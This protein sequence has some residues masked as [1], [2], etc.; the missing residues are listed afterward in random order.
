MNMNKDVLKKVAN[1]LNKLNCTWAIGG[2]VMLNHFG[3]VESPNDIDILI[4]ASQAKQIKEFMDSIGAY[5]KLPSK[6]PFKT[7]EFFG[8]IVDDVMVEFL[9]DFKIELE[10]GKVYEFIL[11]EEAIKEYIMID[12]IKVNLT[13]LEDWF[14]AYSVMKD[15]KNRVPLLKRYFD[16][17][18]IK[19]RDLLERN[20]NNNLPMS[21][22]LDIE[23]ILQQES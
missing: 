14:V 16:Q 9:G 20:M 15:P 18:G 7:E 4:D 5:V 23:S 8:Y 22:K 11:D 1:G 10:N 3:L 13:T 21:V 6:S 2:S 17:Y 12:G 19:Y